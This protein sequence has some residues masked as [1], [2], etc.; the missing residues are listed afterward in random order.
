MS[1]GNDGTNDTPCPRN[2]VFTYWP[3]ETLIARM[4]DKKQSMTG[5]AAAIFVGLVVGI[6]ALKLFGIL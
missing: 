6:L 1:S 2:S 5:V 3:A 4:S